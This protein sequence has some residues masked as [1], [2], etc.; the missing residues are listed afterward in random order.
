MRP[1]SPS[2]CS[3]SRSAPPAPA[4]A[5]DIGPDDEVVITGTVNVP[6]GEHVDRV[7]IVDGI[8]NVAG[9][10]EG[11]IVALRAPVRISGIVDGDVIA[12][13]KPIT[14][15]PSAQVNGDIV[16]ADERPGSQGGR[17]STATCATWMPATSRSRSGRSPRYT[18]RSRGR[19]RSPDTDGG[20]GQSIVGRT[21]IGIRSR[22]RRKCRRNRSREACRQSCRLDIVRLPGTGLP[23][24]TPSTAASGARERV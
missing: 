13:A 1:G 20:H 5:A 11:S 15:T 23:C 6:K 8:V 2:R 16:Y 7:W 24:W 22:P 10:S 18:S 3:R 9:H 14:L 19:S 21:R 17:P 12:I 4:R